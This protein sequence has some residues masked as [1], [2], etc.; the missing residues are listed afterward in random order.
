M[1]IETSIYRTIQF[2]NYN[3]LERE[4]IG[5][6]ELQEIGPRGSPVN[7]LAL[8]VQTKMPRILPCRPALSEAVVD[9]QGTSN[10]NKSSVFASSTPGKAFALGF[11]ISSSYYLC[12]VPICCE[13]LLFRF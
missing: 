4:N 2:L 7:G 12:Q 5:W 6:A 8:I 10:K 11:L 3:I 1:S 9:I 13:L